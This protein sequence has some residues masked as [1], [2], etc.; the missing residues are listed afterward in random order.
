MREMKKKI[1]ELQKENSSRETIDL[2]NKHEIQELKSQLEQMTLKVNFI[3]KNTYFLFI[4][5]FIFFIF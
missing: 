4:P 2:I 5:Y 3:Y 1:E